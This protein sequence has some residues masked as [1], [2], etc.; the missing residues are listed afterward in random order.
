M[1]FASQWGD[2]VS[3]ALRRGPSKVRDALAIRG[4]FIAELWENAERKNLLWVA[5]R[6]INLITTTGL[7]W[8]A[9]NGLLSG[10][11]YLMP[12]SGTPS[13]ALGD[14]MTV[15]A[16]WTEVQ[17][18][19]EAVRQA[20]VG[21]VISPG[22]YSNIASKASFAINTT[23]TIGGAMGVSDSTKGGTAGVTVCGGAFVQ[24]D[25]GAVDGNVL[26]VTY[27]FTH[28]NA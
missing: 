17:D 6:P 22:N 24:G 15:H 21:A 19:D 13:V 26:D 4:G 14:T 11:F 5:T 1:D 28:A 3:A 20:F 16:G 23:V 27:A 7:D 12:I 18:Y 2:R 9:Q 10:T 25:Q 8:L